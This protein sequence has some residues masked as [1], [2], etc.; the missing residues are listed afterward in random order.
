[1][2]GFA[3]RAMFAHH[4]AHSSL[5]RATAGVEITGLLVA[6]VGLEPTTYGL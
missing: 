1:M 6:A 4:G 5:T 2:R 3:P